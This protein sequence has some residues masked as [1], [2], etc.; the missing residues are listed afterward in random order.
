MK[1]FF[2]GGKPKAKQSA[3]NSTFPPLLVL[4]LNP[5]DR[6]DPSLD[7]DGDDD[8][9]DSSDDGGGRRSRG[10]KSGLSLSCASSTVGFVCK[11]L[12]FLLTGFAFGGLCFVGFHRFANVAV[13]TA[14]GV[15]MQGTREEIRAKTEAE[16]ARIALDE[17][18][19]S[20]RRAAFRR[21]H[22][23]SDD[24]QWFTGHVGGPLEGGGEEWQA[25]AGAGGAGGAG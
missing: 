20:K 3:R 2:F 21:H 9:Y 11:Q 18:S 5:T 14:T 22:G 6:G 17:A 1:C 23:G 16:A 12:L 19:E 25:G 7:D 8:G 24:P 10:T 13:R 15:N 4:L